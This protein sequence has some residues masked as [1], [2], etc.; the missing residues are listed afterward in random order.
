MTKVDADHV[1]G[2]EV[3]HEVGQVTVPDARDVVRH[4]QEG[5]RGRPITLEGEVGLRSSTQT[6]V[7]PSKTERSQFDSV[8]T[9]KVFQFW[10]IVCKC[11]LSNI[12][13]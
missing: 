11:R 12:L 9:S 5:V 13:N 8:A 10:C 4:T 1:A 2:V 7:P 6:Q 3:D